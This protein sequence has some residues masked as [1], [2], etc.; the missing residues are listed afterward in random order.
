[1]H[2]LTAPH[3]QIVASKSILNKNCNPFVQLL[4]LSLFTCSDLR[5]V[6][7]RL[8]K[9]DPHVYERMSDVTHSMKSWIY[10]CLY[11]A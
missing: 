9:A 8:N 4:M 10:E 3:V 7:V 5:F 1:M 11:H 6:F 2:V